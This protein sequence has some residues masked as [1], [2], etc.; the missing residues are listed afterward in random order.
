MPLLKIGLQIL[1][2]THHSL[3]WGLIALCPVYQDP[4][5]SCLSSHIHPADQVTAPLKGL[6]THSVRRKKKP[7]CM[8]DLNV[9]HITIFS[10]S[11]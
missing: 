3:F 9:S 7:Q 11:G 5:H 8:Y 10:L 4:E 2:Q 6:V 1:V